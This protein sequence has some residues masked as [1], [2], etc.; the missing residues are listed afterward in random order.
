[1]SDPVCT[2]RP[3]SGAGTTPCRQAREI[4]E[5]PDMK[6]NYVAW[7]RMVAACPVALATIKQAMEKANGR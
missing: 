5:R 3:P 7:A 1:M 4:A 2:C 6:W